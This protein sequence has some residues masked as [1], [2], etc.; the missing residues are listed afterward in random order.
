VDLEATPPTAAI[1][2]DGSHVAVG[3]YRTQ[4]P[5]DGKQ[6]EL[7]VLAD[8]YESRTMVFRDE[9]PPGRIELVATVRNAEGLN[10][11][12]S[13]LAT[14]TQGARQH[15]SPSAAA[16]SGSEPTRARAT[17]V[18]TSTLVRP[19]PTTKG[20]SEPETGSLARSAGPQVAAVN[21]AATGGAPPSARVDVIEAQWP[22]VRIVDEAKPR[23]QIIE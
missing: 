9:P 15:T 6:H 20:T 2:L 1:L 12:G 10:G 11:P 18:R 7:R 23:V 21:N 5:R 13:A 19:I 3:R 4:L 14:A 17:P 22:R 8:G 16:R